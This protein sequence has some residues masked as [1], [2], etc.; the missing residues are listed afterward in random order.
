MN[1]AIEQ[2]TVGES[3]FDRMLDIK[4]KT[5]LIKLARKLIK[6][7]NKLQNMFDNY[8]IKFTKNSISIKYNYK[9]G[10]KDD[11]LD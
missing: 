11:T 6:Q 2:T 10:D 9:K 1:N 7:T 8:E 5:Y 3:D 4:R